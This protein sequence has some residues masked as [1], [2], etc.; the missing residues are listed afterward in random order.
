M[1]AFLQRRRRKGLWRVLDSDSVERAVATALALFALGTCLL[2]VGLLMVAGVV[3]HK[4]GQEKGILFLGALTFMPGFYSTRIAYYAWRGRGTY[5][6]A[7]LP[8]G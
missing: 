1:D 7:Q 6:Y 3:P 8:S 2:A 5:S 4:E